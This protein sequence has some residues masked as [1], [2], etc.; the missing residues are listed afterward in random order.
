MG[1][2]QVLKTMQDTRTQTEMAADLGISQGAYS[3]FLSGR[4]IA[5]R[6]ARQIMLRHPELREVLAAE[7]LNPTKEGE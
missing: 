7:L 5:H 2:V 4:R 1:L 3:K 6:L